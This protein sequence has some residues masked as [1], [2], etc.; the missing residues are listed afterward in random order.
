MFGVATTCTLV[1][2]NKYLKAC[3][4]SMFIVEDQRTRH[5]LLVPPNVG[6]YPPNQTVSHF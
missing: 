6:T 3:A 1:N 5:R 2:R 4:A